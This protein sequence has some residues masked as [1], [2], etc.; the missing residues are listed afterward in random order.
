MDRRTALAYRR[1]ADDWI[2]RR[3]P[4]AIDDGRLPAFL[5]RVRAHGVVADLGCGPG[6]YAAAMARSGRRA[7]ALDLCPAMLAECGLRA[8][9]AQRTRGDLEMLPI[10][11]GSLDGAWAANC[12][13]HVRPAEMALALADLHA[14]LRPGAPVALTLTRLEGV[15]PTARETQRGEATRRSTEELRGRLFTAVSAERAHALLL[16]A[17]FESIRIQ[18]LPSDDFWHAISAR[19]ARTLADLVRPRLRLLICGLNPSLYSADAGIPFARP[20]NRFWPAAIGAGLVDTARD[21][22]AALVRGIGFTDLVKRATPGASELSPREYEAGLER[23]AAL[24]RLYRPKA[25][26]FVGLDGWRAAVDRR[27]QSGWI[28]GGFAGSAAYLMPSTSGRNA[29]IGVTELANHLR[30]AALSGVK[31]DRDRD[32]RQRQSK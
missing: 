16:G 6:W 15:R 11:P 5:R 24:V 3:G 31:R 18:R 25:L 1:A 20:G 28:R 27:A 4:S 21:S 22:R 8:P 32:S 2:P 30:V 19:R 9:Q 7:L 23:V 12:Y 17:G 13:C 10:L 14:A 26:C 29:R